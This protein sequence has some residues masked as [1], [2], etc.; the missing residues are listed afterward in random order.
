LHGNWVIGTDGDRTNSD[1][2]RGI[3]RQLHGG[4]SSDANKFQFRWLAT[5]MIAIPP[6]FDETDFNIKTTADASIHR[7][8]G[9]A[10]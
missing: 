4:I 10:S 2:S 5:S 8:S 7:F 1:A 9:G 6:C 3:S